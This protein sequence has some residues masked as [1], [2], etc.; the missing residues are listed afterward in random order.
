MDIIVIITLIGTLIAIFVGVIEIIKFLKENRIKRPNGLSK[1][2]KLTVSL[3]NPQP[4]K[5]FVGRTDELATALKLL[6]SDV[7]NSSVALCGMGGIGKSTLARKICKELEDRYQI[8]W[9][10]FGENP[11]I[12]RILDRWAQQ[13]GINVTE[14][15]DVKNKASAVRDYLRGFSGNLLIVIDDVWDRENFLFMRDNAISENVKLLITT[16]DTELARQFDLEKIIELPVFSNE[17]VKTYF[18]KVFSKSNASE[19]QI[20]SVGLLVGN[21]PLF[22][23][24][25]THIEDDF[26]DLEEVLANNRNRIESESEHCFDASYRHLPTNAQNCFR[27]TGAFSNVCFSQDAISKIAGKDA[28]IEVY[29]LLKR[30]LISRNENGDLTQHI[31][32]NNYAHK[33]LIQQGEEKVVKL[34]HADYYVSLPNSNN[35]NLW[36][37]YFDQIKRS[38][39]T[40]LYWNSENIFKYFERITAFFT[41]RARWHEIIIYSLQALDLAE[42]NK[43]TKEQAELNSLIGYYYWQLGEYTNA[44]ESLNIGLKISQE[45]SEPFYEANCYNTLGLVKRGE[46]E[47]KDSLDFFLKS[48]EIRK[49]LGYQIGVAYNLHNIGYTYI[50]MREYDFAQGKLQECIELFDQILENENDLSEWD[51]SE[52]Q[53]GKL[54]GINSY[55]SVLLFQGK[56]EVALKICIEGLKFAEEVGEYAGICRLEGNIGKVYRE[57]NMNTEALAAFNRSLIAAEKCGHLRGQ[58]RALIWSGQV[59]LMDG[60]YN[61][62]LQFLNRGLDIL[63][64]LAQPKD[65]STIHRMLARVLKESG[66]LDDAKAEYE[67]AINLSKQSD[68]NLGEG[69]GR[70]ELIE[71]FPASCNE[72]SLLHAN[73]LLEQAGFKSYEDAKLFENQTFSI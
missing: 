35:W 23:E 7:N 46:K 44:R 42:K 36:D 59:Q 17:D 70:R 15:T 30:R 2:N 61:E 54:L 25:I 5:N 4:P 1:R 3:T 9:T 68:D 19:K 47:Y 64:L 72:E 22:V 28:R 55:S 14:I 57:E 62:S 67:I 40:L 31:L 48:L 49:R 50:Q 34:A 6:R 26:S 41:I 71:L 45:N 20:E 13:I 58:V 65:I 12:I 39:E 60:K 29:T 8:I 33:L 10:D 69:I 24:I 38:W 11:D 51:R 27:M 32:L 63:K 16:R 52:A 18:K 66:K 21:L 73:K 56:K 53:I 43:N 37:K